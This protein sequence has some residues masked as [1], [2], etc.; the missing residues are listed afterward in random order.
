MREIQLT[1]GLVAIV[2]DEDFGWLNKFKWCAKKG[3]NTF[4]AVR[5]MQVDGKAKTIRMHRL[6]MN[7]PKE[8]L[9]DHDNGNGLFNCKKNLRFCTNQENQH[10]QH[11]PNRSNKLGIKGVRWNERR[12]K[13]M[14]QIK[15]NN[16]DIH[17]GCFNVL[18]DADSAYR[19]AED[20][21]FGKFARKVG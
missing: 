11:H 2:D 21:Y 15:I 20:K 14:V 12:K 16:K 18:G 7:A 4:Y 13:F 17:I 1:Q 3:R 8:V 6:I 19:I 5:G 9:I 10:N